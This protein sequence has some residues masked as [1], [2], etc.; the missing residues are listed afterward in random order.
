MSWL[1]VYP[2]RLQALQPV[3]TLPLT[4]TAPKKPAL[5]LHT[6]WAPLASIV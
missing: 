5:H 6:A 2:A 1:M 4:E 3:A